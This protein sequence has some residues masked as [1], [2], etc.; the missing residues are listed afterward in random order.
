MLQAFAVSEPGEQPD[1]CGE[2]VEDARAVSPQ[3][4]DS[5]GGV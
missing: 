2:E 5:S 4:R 1:V 3:L